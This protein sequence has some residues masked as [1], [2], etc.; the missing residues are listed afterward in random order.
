MGKRTF[1]AYRSEVQTLNHEQTATFYFESDTGPVSNVVCTGG[2]IDISDFRGY[3][4]SFYFIISINGEKLFESNEI[5]NQNESTHSFR[6]YMDT[7]YNFEAQRIMTIPSGGNIKI[8]VIDN[9]ESSH[10]IC[11]FRSNC[12]IT[13]NAYYDDP[14]I[15][16]NNNPPTSVSVSPSS[17]SGTTAT[18][19]WSGASAGNNNSISGYR[20]FHT[21]SADGSSWD[22]TWEH[23]D[24][25]STSTSGSTTVDVHSAIGYYRKYRVATLSPHGENY[26]STSSSWSNAVLKTTATTAC[27]APTALSVNSTLAEGNVTLSW[28]GAGAGT[29]NSISSYLIQYRDSSDNSNWGSWTNLQTVSSTSSSGTLSVS[30]PSIRGYYRQYRIRTQGSAGSSYYSGYKT[31]SNT[32]R[33]N[34]LPTAP[35]ISAPVAGSSTFN[36]TPRVLITAG[37]ETDGAKMNPRILNAAGSTVT[38]GFSSTSLSNSGKTVYK[39]SASVTDG[40]KTLIVD[41]QDANFTSAYSDGQSVTFIVENLSITDF[42]VTAGVTH[43]K[44]THMNELQNA[45]NKVRAY[46]GLN[47]YA[48]SA[49]TG[50]ATK[51]KD[52]ATHLNQM[53]TAINEIITYINNY[54]SANTTNDVSVNWIA[55]NNNNPNAAAINQIY[56]VLQTL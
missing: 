50:G 21:N 20:I 29:A 44:A 48:F 55:L 24:V 17:T 38:T 42:P 41:M 16:S 34:S 43:V 9:D 12:T 4:K 52:W 53:R 40:S 26:G 51:I 22:G 15:I 13:I 47:A 30:P 10:N 36:K 27:S 56:T 35:I 11:S 19:S 1:T 46:Y 32:L 5:N 6:T 54:D 31:S 49:I 45:I 33:K 18:L 37:T 39:H 2:E 14:I 8:K 25:S 28:S 7:R 3:S 23:K